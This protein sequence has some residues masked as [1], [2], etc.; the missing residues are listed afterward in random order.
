MFPKTLSGDHER[1]VYKWTKQIN[2]V[3]GTAEYVNCTIL[4]EADAEFHVWYSFCL[5]GGQFECKTPNIHC[6][7][8]IY[9]VKHLWGILL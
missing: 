3:Q 1:V 9:K 5:K 6:L 2:T 7:N 8:F 4:G